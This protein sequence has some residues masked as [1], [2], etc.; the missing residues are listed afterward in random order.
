V[1]DSPDLRTIGATTLVEGRYFCE[2]PRWHDDRFWF[3]D[4]YAHEV[5]SVGLD[6]DV[7]NEVDFGDERPSGLGW[8]PDGRLLVVAML[9]RKVM[10][11]EHDGSLVEH[12]DLGDVATFHCNDMLVDA[13][14]RA[15]VG[16][17]GFDLDGTLASMGVEG[18]LGALA[19]D[20]SP[21]TA[22][23]ARVD[24][25]GTVSV[26]ADDLAFP[27]GVVTLDEGSTLVVAQSL[28]LELTAFDK[29]ADGTLSQRRTWASL[30]GTDGSAAVP[31]GIDVDD[32]GGIWVANATGPE[33]L[34]VEEGGIV[35]H[36]VT[37]SQPAFACALGG[38]DRRHL[39]VCTA[40]GSDAEEAA[41]QP[42]GKLELAE[43]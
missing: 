41:A 27:N 35:T 15:Y 3:S 31:D 17:F 32:R 8:L 25:D 4:F 16:N 13:E 11:R 39:L 33:V 34:R 40:A 21:Y 6:G 30:V 2:G 43:V 22:V 28:G 26:G 29:A 7:R 36:R 37:T 9:A 1:E 42:A 20:R 19:T 10:R 5:C 38:P 12:A 24:P 23:L 14:G 18:L